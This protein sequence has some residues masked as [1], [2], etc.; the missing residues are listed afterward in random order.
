MGCTSPS[1]EVLA[2]PR[3]IGA[4]LD[5]IAEPWSTGCYVGLPRPGTLT[6]IG[7]ALRTPCGRVHWAGTETAVEG[8]GYI[9]GAVESGERAATELSPRLYTRR[10]H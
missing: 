7:E 1:L 6:A 10:P 3:Q 5:W 9:D 4:D 2:T 8:C